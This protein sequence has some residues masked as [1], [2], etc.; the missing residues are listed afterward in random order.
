[1]TQALTA[2]FTGGLS[3]AAMALAWTDWSIHLAA[4]PGKRAE[5]MLKAWRKYSRLA[6]YMARRAAIPRRRR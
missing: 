5:L 3:P 4:A 6:G 2:R 1:M